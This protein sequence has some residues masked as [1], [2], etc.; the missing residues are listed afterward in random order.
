[1]TYHNNRNYLMYVVACIALTAI[2]CGVS[3]QL[4]TVAPTA[5]AAHVTAVIPTF[6]TVAETVNKDE[7][8][9]Q[10]TTIAPLHIRACAGIDCD[11]LAYLAAGVS[12]DVKVTG[13][14][15]PGCA[16]AAWYAVESGGV[17]GFVC[18]LYVKEMK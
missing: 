6:S 16:G 11:I 14:S 7:T 17:A 13:I 9:L 5:K 2:S 12:V 15:G 18:S 3:A 10:F 1:M 4:P 8:N